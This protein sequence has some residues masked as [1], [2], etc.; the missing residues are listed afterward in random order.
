MTLEI[1]NHDPLDLHSSELPLQNDTFYIHTLSELECAKNPDVSIALNDY[2][3]SQFGIKVFSALVTR[4]F[5][6]AERA[7]I[8]LLPRQILTPCIESISTVLLC[9]ILGL[10]PLLGGFTTDTFHHASVDKSAALKTK[11]IQWRRT[12]DGNILLDQQTVQLT[13]EPLASLSGRVIDSIKTKSGE[14]LVDYHLDNLRGIIGPSS[15]T[16]CW[17]FFYDCLI[18]AERKPEFCF[19]RTSEDRVVRKPTLEI[20]FETAEPR[21]IRPPASWYYPIMFSLFVDKMILLE[22]YENPRGSVS[23]ARNLF[24]L[25]S[26]EILKAT[27]H[28]PRV[29]EIPPLSKEMLFL[30]TH[31]LKEGPSALTRLR[32]SAYELAQEVFSTNG[33]G[34]ILDLA[35]SIASCVLQ[36]GKDSS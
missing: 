13:S 7:P 9:E 33:T 5:P 25:T 4:H 31:I 3:A 36:Y 28:R 35:H 2:L 15:T 11:E 24:Q 20:D 30:N 34:S 8:A 12:R 6:N 27:G 14:S 16:D 26:Q 19:V 22:T 29:I 23:E 1:T 32:A 21:D 10:N 18:T 17:A